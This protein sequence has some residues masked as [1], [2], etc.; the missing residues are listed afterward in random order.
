VSPPTALSP[1]AAAAVT[2]G[3]PFK[4]TMLTWKYTIP[5]FVVPFVFTLNP[6]GTAILLQGSAAEIALATSMA[7]AGVI[8]I[9]AGAG[10]YTWRRATVVE[11]AVAITIG[12]V[13]LALA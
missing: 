3:N 10:G 4:T 9:A 11:R 6:R 13:L 1:F 7:V 5:A 12:L 8:A 2:G